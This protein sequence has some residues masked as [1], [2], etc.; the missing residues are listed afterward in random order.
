MPKNKTKQERIE[1]LEAQ[2]DQ[3]TAQ[4]QKTQAA[5]IQECQLRAERIV[6]LDRENSALRQRMNAGQ[7]GL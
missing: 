4:A 7:P 3:A 6:E 1:E 2:L 5:L